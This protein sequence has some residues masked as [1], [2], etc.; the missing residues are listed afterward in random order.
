MFSERL[1]AKR[2]A[3]RTSFVAYK[4]GS[5]EQR[6]YGQLMVVVVVE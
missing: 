2:A 6:D 5:N 4:A 3:E 1:G